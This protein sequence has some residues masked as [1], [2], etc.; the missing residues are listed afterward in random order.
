MDGCSN[1]DSFSRC[2]STWLVGYHNKL[3][4]FMVNVSAVT[5][6]P[7]EY[8]STPGGNA[9]FSCQTSSVSVV[10]VQWLVNGTELDLYPRTCS[11]PP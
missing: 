10:D 2:F 9:F 4:P 11:Y 8:V 3:L 6:T 5:N 7:E 1:S